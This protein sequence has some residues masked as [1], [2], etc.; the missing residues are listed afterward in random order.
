V[1]R[2]CET[3]VRLTQTPYNDCFNPSTAH[4]WLPWLKRESLDT[5]RIAF[6]MSSLWEET[7]E[8]DTI[9]KLN[10]DFWSNGCRT[11]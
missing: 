8:R 2:P 5:E 10:E 9:A 7:I 11:T 4:Q 3:P 6:T 1:G